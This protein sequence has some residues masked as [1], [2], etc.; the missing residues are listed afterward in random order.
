MS[1]EPDHLFEQVPTEAEITAIRPNPRRPSRAAIK[2][3]KKRVAEL[4]LELIHDLGIK[5]GRI[6][7]ED[8]AQQV[9]DTVAF[10][11]TQNA[12]MNRLNSPAKSSR[13]NDEKQRQFGYTEV[14]RMNVIEY[15]TQRKHLDDEAYGRALIREWLMQ[16]PAGRRLLYSKLMQK[17]L[18]RTLIEQLLDETSDETDT[19]AGARKLVESKLRSMRRLDP[20]KRKRRLWGMLARRG[21]NSDTISQAM[22]GIED[23]IDS[24][25][26]Q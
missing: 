3:G 11:K 22:K 19:V 21:Y 24:D 9:A 15:L 20:L 1:N 8:L 14:T 26:F 16:K 4:P 12:A 25:E 17:G 7:D 18:D 6:W 10:D 5:V 23:L 13:T 2:V